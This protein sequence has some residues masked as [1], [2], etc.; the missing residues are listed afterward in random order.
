MFILG[1]LPL[2]EM[3]EE[4]MK[5]RLIQKIFTPYDMCN[6]LEVIIMCD[7]NMVACPNIAPRNNWVRA[8]GGSPFS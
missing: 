5:R 3:L 7:S 1:C 8:V 2:H 6:A 4:D